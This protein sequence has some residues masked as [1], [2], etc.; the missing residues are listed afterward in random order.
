VRV[1][2]AFIPWQEFEVHT[3]MKP[4]NMEKEF[5]RAITRR[6]ESRVRYGWKGESHTDAYERNIAADRSNVAK[7]RY[8][9]LSHTGL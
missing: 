9:E 3:R 2:L 5:G 1:M 7:H 6:A 4:G 8:C